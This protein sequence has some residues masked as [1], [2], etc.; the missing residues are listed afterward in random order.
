M[1]SVRKHVRIARS[2][3]DVW[4]VIGD[5][6]AIASWSPNIEASPVSGNRRHI[7]YAAGFSTE[8]EIVTCDNA[9]RRFQYRIL[10]CPVPV[11]YLGTVDVIEDGEGALVIYSAE[12]RPDDLAEYTDETIG[13]GLAG[14][15]DYLERGSTAFPF[16]T[17]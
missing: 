17:T 6:S 12:I 5:A 11:D 2:A 3:D 15:K 4:K 10:E 1:S 9:L 13:R 7:D 16:G 8:E 14:L